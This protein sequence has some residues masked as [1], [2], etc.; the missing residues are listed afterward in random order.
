[1][2]YVAPAREIGI[3]IG[4]VLGARLLREGHLARRALGAAA[5]VVGV[6]ALARG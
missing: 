5:M 6:I 2:S 4:A 1:V 3:L